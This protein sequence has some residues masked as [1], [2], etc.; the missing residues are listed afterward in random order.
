MNDLTAICC[1][2]C[3]NQLLAGDKKLLCSSCNTTYETL[4]SGFIDFSENNPPVQ[5]R[6]LQSQMEVDFY[7]NDKFER[8][9]AECNLNNIKECLSRF[10]N[11]ALLDIGCGAGG[12]YKVVEEFCVHYYGCD[13]SDVEGSF[14]PCSGV[15]LIHNDI[16]KTLPIKNESID[17]I[18]LFASYD[19]LPQPEAV[20]QDAWQK[21]KPGGHMLINMTNYG[22]WLKTLINKLSGKQLFKNEHEHYCVHSPQTLEHEI[23]CFI[24]EAKL[25]YSESDYVYLPNLPKKLSFVYFSTWWIRFLD[26]LTKTVF[27]KIF[28]MKERG[29]LMTLVFQKPGDSK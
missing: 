4:K 18:A 5:E 29:S 25:L 15:F 23:K 7:S 6:G 28:R 12:M 10:S 9:L 17:C 1:P 27:Y 22:F 13:P 24:P 16:S 11:S 26:G 8:F 3:Q 21:L 14:E 20:I 2:C 19:H